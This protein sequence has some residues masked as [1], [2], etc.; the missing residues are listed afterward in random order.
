LNHHA[1][2]PL[3]PHAGIP[4]VSIVVPVY[5]AAKHL[6]RLLDSIVNQTYR[7]L[8]IILVDDG[9]TD[10]SGDISEQRKSEDSRIV[11]L[12]QTNGGEAS[13]RN[14]GLSL[15]SG[16]YVYF[17]DADDELPLD[18]IE[19]L[20]GGM[21]NDIDLVCGSYL[22]RDDDGVTRIAALL[23]ERYTVSQLAYDVS[24]DMTEYRMNYVMYPCN[25]KLYRSSLI[26]SNYIK[27]KEEY[28][29]EGCV[30][31]V[32]DY[33]STCKRC[34]KNVFSATYI[35]YRFPITRVQG[36]GYVYPDAFEQLNAITSGYLKLISDRKTDNIGTV[37]TVTHTVYQI[38]VDRLI[39]IL[40]QSTAYE[41]YFDDY[42]KVLQKLLNDAITREGICFYR[43]KRLTDSYLIPF[44][45][46]H[47][48]VHLLLLSLRHRAKRFL[49]VHGKRTAV[50]MI[51]SRNVK[52]LNLPRR[53][54]L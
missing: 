35:Y 43:R 51:Y 24:T 17:S 14:S 39:F 32:I 34:I 8:E 18:A 7:Q 37:D 20:V 25:G 42:V 30:E 15:V 1:E 28:N 12:H 38:H 16:E 40:V 11:V 6:T 13:A 5:N 31:F 4:T 46:R 26:K 41:E 22:I 21:D 53:D 27:F 44:F 19:I 9:S 36:L 50:K 23:C 45:I 48:F 33:L 3:E 47:R 52:P 29:I 49:R 2:Q 54:A 10:D